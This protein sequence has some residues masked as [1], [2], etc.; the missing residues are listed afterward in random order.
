[1]VTGRPN[2]GMVSGMVKVENPTLVIADDDQSCRSAVQ[3]ALETVGYRTVAAS[4]GL[5]AVEVIL[6]HEIHLGVFDVH[7]PE[8]TG[9]DALRFLR[10]KRIYV[11]IIVMTSDQ[12]SAIHE[13]A[14]HEGA[15][16][17]V[18]KPIDLTVIRDTVR[19]A[20]EKYS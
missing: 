1:M 4:T 19:F 20:L 10:K 11:P 2:S 15:L 6:H 16:S 18:L 7:M 13:R 5:E 12:S 8:M 3:E 17:L 9:I 14:M